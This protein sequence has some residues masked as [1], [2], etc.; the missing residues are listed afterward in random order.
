MDNALLKAILLDHTGEVRVE[1]L[2]SLL[3]RILAI[4][5]TRSLEI[6]EGSL[7]AHDAD[8]LVTGLSSPKRC[9]LV[10]RESGRPFHL[11]REHIDIDGERVK[12][13]FYCKETAEEAAR[14]RVEVEWEADDPE[15]DFLEA[16]PP[17]KVT[18][19]EGVEAWD[20]RAVC[21]Y[22]SEEYGWLVAG[23][24]EVARGE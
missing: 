13:T 22:L 16:A 24:R 19:P 2:A 17:A 1:A 21:D 8:H 11:Y 4:A 23:Y 15:A 14:A 5:G 18:L 7:S 6:Y 12:V 9:D 3:R 10:V 20:N